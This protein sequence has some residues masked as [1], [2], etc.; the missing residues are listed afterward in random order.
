[1]NYYP[2]VLL[3]G[4]SFNNYT[5]MGITLTNLFADWPREN[6]AVWAEGIEPELCAMIRPCA[7]YIGNVKPSLGKTMA[8]RKLTFNDRC[9]D[10][11][12]KQYHKT[13]IQELRVNTLIPAEQLAEAISFNPDIVFCALGSDVKT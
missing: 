1:M 9:I 5:G 12:K 2:H 13:G 4:H 11:L 8:K 10:F 6:I 3:F 7:K